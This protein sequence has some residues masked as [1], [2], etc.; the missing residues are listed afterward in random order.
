MYEDYTHALG[1]LALLDLLDWMLE[2]R[3]E[4]LVPLL[5]GCQVEMVKKVLEH[6]EHLLHHLKCQL[7]RHFCCCWTA[8]DAAGLPVQDLDCPCL[9]QWRGWVVKK[10]LGFAECL[11]HRPLNQFEDLEG[12]GKL[13]AAAA[14]WTARCRKF[15]GILHL[16]NTWDS[17]PRLV[18]P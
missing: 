14:G 4:P 18:I 17:S 6:A 2:V 16:Q 7:D 9:G 12:A 8:G 1:L 10:V 5:A 3:L 11:L 13:L 15:A